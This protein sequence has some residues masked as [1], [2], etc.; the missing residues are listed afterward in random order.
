MP[1]LNWNMRKIEVSG[2]NGVKRQ[3]TWRL[4]GKKECNGSGSQI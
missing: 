4:E 2:G 1:K 3:G